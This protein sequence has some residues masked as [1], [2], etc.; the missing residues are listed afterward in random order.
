VE[1][2]GPL[3]CNGPG[4]N[5]Y[6]QIPG[7][8]IIG[9]PRLDTLFINGATQA[10]LFGEQ[11]YGRACRPGPVDMTTFMKDPHWYVAVGGFGYTSGSIT[12]SLVTKEPVLAYLT[13]SR[14]DILPGEQRSP[15]GH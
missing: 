7:G 8:Q 15:F 2:W 5:S 14:F 1:L 9:Y 11:A 10:R 12:T 3:T 4:T 13:R 6:Y